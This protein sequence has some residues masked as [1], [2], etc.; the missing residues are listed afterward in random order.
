M[1][2]LFLLII[3]YSEF[4]NY[5]ISHFRNLIKTAHSPNESHRPFSIRAIRAAAFVLGLMRLPESG[6]AISRGVSVVQY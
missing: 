3:C 2:A 4:L 6:N 1:S 5:S